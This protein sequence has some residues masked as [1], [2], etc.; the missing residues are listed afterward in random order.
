MHSECSLQQQSKQDD[1][2]EVSPAKAWAA[3]TVRAAPIM[4]QTMRRQ[5]HAVLAGATAADSKHG[6]APPASHLS[7]SRCASAAEA[8]RSTA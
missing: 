7:Y 3:C 5:Q 4:P 1:G 2:V 8:K 6:S